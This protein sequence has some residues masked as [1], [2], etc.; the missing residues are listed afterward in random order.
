MKQGYFTFVLHSHLPYVRSAGRW[1]HGEEMIHEAL[2]ETY[3][4]LLNALYDLKREGIEPRLTIGLTPILLEQIADRD[5]LAHFE[6]YLDEEI[7]VA[8]AD[9]ARFDAGGDPRLKYLADFHARW[10]QAVKDSYEHRYGRD[11]VGAFRRLR[12]DGNLDVMTSAATHGYLPLFDRDSSIHGQLT[13]GLEATRRHLGHAPFGIWLPECGYRPAYYRSGENGA[14][15]RPGLEEFLAELNLLYFVTD[16]QVIEGGRIVGKAAGDVHG[17]YGGLPKRDLAAGDSAGTGP[18]ERTTARPYY[19][20]SSRVAVYGRDARTGTQVWSATSGYPGDFRY[21]EFHRKDSTSGL[22]YWRVTGADVALDHKELYDPVAALDQTAAHADHFVGLV[23]EISARYHAGHDRPGLIVSA[24][25][26]ELFGHWWFEG[27]DWL[28]GVL[29]RL[30]TNEQVGLT[31]ANQYL[32]RY[33]PEDALTLSESSWGAGGN[34]WTW[35]NPQ[36]EWIWP[37]IHGAERRMEGLVAENLDAAGWRVKAMNQLAREL[38]LLQSSDW[39]FLIST[40]QAKEYAT[41]RFQQHLAR[42]NH[43]AMI[44]ESKHFGPEEERFLDATASLDNPFPTIDF[45]AF[46]E[47][48]WRENRPSGS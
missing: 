41:G 23:E 27:I 37:L 39:P 4:P 22:Q 13:T 32:E 47:E 19:V 12:E 17:P 46:K 9:G 5:V 2:A 11:V 48:N 15:Y 30:A 28:K 34:H 25:D 35:L 31:T 1:P 29:R 14:G 18:S 26:T 40:G 38:L 44:V 3:V 45:R 16:T 24:Y 42:F 33:P 21:R 20:Q 7:E 10:Y 8:K 6:L 43:L 36:T